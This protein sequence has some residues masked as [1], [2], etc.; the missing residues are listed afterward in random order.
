MSK[1][2]KPNI[3][4]VNDYLS[5]T[6]KSIT[7]NQGVILAD[8]KTSLISTDDFINKNG[9]LIKGGDA[10]IASINVNKKINLYINK[11]FAIIKL[12]QFKVRLFKQ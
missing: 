3:Y 9:G 7:N 5:L 11:A 1:T 2:L 12:K 4:L 6:G 8:E 10:Q